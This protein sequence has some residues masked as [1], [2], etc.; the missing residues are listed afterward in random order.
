MKKMHL[1]TISIFLVLS[2]LGCSNQNGSPSETN[3]SSSSAVFEEP[4]TET[5]E[6]IV[7]DIP[8][9]NLNMDAESVLNSYY[10]AQNSPAFEIFQENIF[11]T[12]LIN[13]TAE[14]SSLKNVVWNY[15]TFAQYHILDNELNSIPENDELYY[16]T[17]SADNDKFGYI[18][19]FYDGSSLKRIDVAETKYNY[20]LK[21]VLEELVDLISFT[22]VDF[23][24]VVASRISLVDDERNKSHEV[25]RLTDTFGNELMYSFAGSVLKNHTDIILPDQS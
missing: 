7:T 4:E 2:I 13:W 14:I 25:I 23:S 3:S 10:D 21:A 11:N 5:S 16:C 20:D 6:S 9:V 17:F 12:L 15:E 22:G 24:T 1:I 18:V 19:M 8:E